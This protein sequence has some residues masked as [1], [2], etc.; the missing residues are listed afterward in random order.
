MGCVLFFLGFYLG[1]VGIVGSLL[2][3]PMSICIGDC[4]N[5]QIVITIIW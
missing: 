1:H 2:G 4:S 3:C 5:T